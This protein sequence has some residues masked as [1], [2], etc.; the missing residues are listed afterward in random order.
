M[1]N[2]HRL[3]FQRCRAA[4]LKMK[5]HELFQVFIAG[6]K[7]STSSSPLVALLCQGFF[8]TDGSFKQYP[9]MYPG[10]RYTSIPLRP[11]FAATIIPL[12][13]EDL[14][15]LS[16]WKS[17]LETPIVFTDSMY[18][19]K[20]YLIIYFEFCFSVPARRRETSRNAWRLFCTLRRPRTTASPRRNS[21]E[22][23]YYPL[24][25]KLMEKELNVPWL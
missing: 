8:R 4:Q 21:F 19:L 13:L 25:G 22:S 11:S 3:R 14:F 23:F 20:K 2:Q 6:P 18:R 17:F 24:V 9:R 5:K 15:D 7:G 16:D 1:G 12:L 10:I